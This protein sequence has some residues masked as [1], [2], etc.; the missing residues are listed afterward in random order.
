MANNN[1]IF[2][3]AIAGA[4]AGIGSRWLTSVS[5]ST[6]PSMANVINAFATAFD[7]QIP[8]IASPGATRSEA[9]LAQSICQAFWSDRMPKDLLSSDYTEAAQ[10]LAQLYTDVATKLTADT[11]AF[12]DQPLSNVFWVDKNT[13]VPA[14]SRNGS[15]GLP[16]GT[17][18]AAIDAVKARANDSGIVLICPADYSAEALDF[19]GVAAGSELSLVGYAPIPSAG[20]GAGSVILGNLTAGNTAIIHYTGVTFGTL[21]A[22]TDLIVTINDSLGVTVTASDIDEIALT[23]SFLTGTLVTTVGDLTSLSAN[24]SQVGAITVAGALGQFLASNCPC[25]TI[26]VTGT[27][28]LL[29]VENSSFGALTINQLNELQ[30]NFTTFAD[31]TVTTTLGT[32]NLNDC[33]TGII[34]AANIT[35][36]RAIDCNLGN[37]VVSGTVTT[38]VINDCPVVGTYSVA[39]LGTGRIVG[40]NLAG[41]INFG[42]AAGTLTIN[43][44]TGTACVF[45]VQTLRLMNFEAIT[46]FSITGVTNQFFDSFSEK[47][48]QKVGIA[49]NTTIIESLDLSVP[50]ATRINNANGTI[51]PASFA[52]YS[53]SALAFTNNRVWT[54]DPAGSVVNQLVAVERWDSSAFTLTIDPGGLFVFPAGGPPLRVYFRCTVAGTTFVVHLVEL[55]N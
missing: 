9:A 17:V 7:A 23:S 2:N 51:T 29:Q 28:G 54:I 19:T 18:Q 55:M 22:G 40:C 44:G 1:L 6:Y 21:T 30:A 32:L 27:L 24:D 14:A 4:S 52:R 3:A 48:A 37:L 20:A 36:F 45:T 8:S 53:K 13:S 15:Q 42:A 41:A 5:E 34:T 11:S 33:V 46:S 31:I 39:A 47:S 12:A 26:Q 43:G 25:S 10:T 49:F 38:Y 35:S 50:R 16:F